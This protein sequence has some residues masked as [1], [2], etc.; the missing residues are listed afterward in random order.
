MKTM[1]KT[2]FTFLALAITTFAFSQTVDDGIKFIYYGKTKSAVAALEK[3]VAAKKDAIST[4][5]LGQAYMEDYEASNYSNDGLAKA[6]ALYQQA[7]QG[8]MNDPWIIVGSAHVTLLEGGDLNKAK[9]QFEVAIT[10]APKGKKGV[11]NADILNAIG[12]ANADGDS[13]HGDAQYGVDKLKRAKEI[14]LKNPDIDINLGICYLKLGSEHG[15]DA[16]QAF[17]DA[18]IRDP[19]YAAGY[20]RVGHIYQSQ[21]NKPSMDEWYGKAIAADPAYAPVYFAYYVY[22]EEKDVNAAKEYLDKYIANADQDCNTSYFQ[23][24]YLFRAGKYQESLNIGKAMEA[25]ECKTFPK[26]NILYAYNYDRLG[27]SLQAKTYLQKFFA[28]AAGA[29]DPDYY[30]LAAKVYAKFPGFEDTASVYL[31][32]AIEVDT[33]KRDEI[34]Y[35]TTAI[36]LMT[37]A[38]KVLQEIEWLNVRAK[39]RGDTKLPEVDYY[40]LGTSVVAAMDVTKDSVSIMQQYTF[41]DSIAKAYIAAYPDKPQGY[42]LRVNAAKKADRDSTWGLA[43]EPI[44]TANDFYRKDTA[45]Y[46][47]NFIFANDY[48]LFSYYYFHAKGMA[49]IDQYKKAVIYLDDILTVTAPGSAEYNFAK[50]TGDKLKAAIKKYEDS[51]NGSSKPAAGA[52]K[53]GAK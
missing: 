30:V 40:K 26:I 7:L 25:G 46:A 28:T 14:D 18:T 12:R 33:I 21:D 52:A 37:K 50:D 47:K 24:N 1:K 4:Y 17:E 3:V 48:Y 45:A 23:A 19:K 6:K 20:Y 10:M 51:H 43:I 22:Y 15:G 2:A 31:H 27:D 32:K 9:Q 42:T 29:I 8:G 44:T 13:K 5:W 39:L 41:D 53:P 16:E 34:S 35:A 49:R 36:N 38:N 11:E